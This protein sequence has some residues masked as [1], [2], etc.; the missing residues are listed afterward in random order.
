MSDDGILKSEDDAI[1]YSEKDLA[2]IYKLVN[3]IRS[4]GASIPEVVWSIHSL[5]NCVI[6]NVRNEEWNDSKLVKQQP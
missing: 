2:V 5:L 3:E 4:R 6:D 1:L